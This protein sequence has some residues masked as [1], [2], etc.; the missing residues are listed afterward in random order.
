MDTWSFLAIFCSES[1]FFLTTAFLTLLTLSWV[2]AEGRF[3]G[4]RR[5][6]RSWFVPFTAGSAKLPTFDAPVSFK[7]GKP[8]LDSVEGKMPAALLCKRSDGSLPASPPDDNGDI[9]VSA[10][11]VKPNFMKPV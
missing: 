10:R 11:T 5:F 7:F 3:C 1:G 2:H 4:G 6:A 9:I 8:S